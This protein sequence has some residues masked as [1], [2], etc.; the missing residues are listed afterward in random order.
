[1]KARRYLKG[2]K[3]LQLLNNDQHPYNDDSNKGE[4]IIKN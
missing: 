1:M 3:G 2:C 4:I